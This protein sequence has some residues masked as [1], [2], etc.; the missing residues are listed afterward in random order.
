[1]HAVY[2]AGVPC[3]AWSSWCGLRPKA[4]MAVSRMARPIVAFARK[5]EPN[6]FPLLFSPI[7]SR[8][9]PFTIRKGAVPVVL[10]QIARVAYPSLVSDSQAASTTGKYS[11]RQPASAALIAASRTV[12]CRFRCG[13]EKTTSSG[14]RLVMTRNSA[15]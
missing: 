11:G 3:V 5:P 12:H 9:G 8:T 7:R 15:R 4:L 2:F 14:S 13:I 10:C 1:M 6:T